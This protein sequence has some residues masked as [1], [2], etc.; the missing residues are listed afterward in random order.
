MIIEHILDPYPRRMW[1]A[2][3]E[4]F[5]KIK[6]EFKFLCQ[7]DCEM[8]NDEIINLYDAF[9]FD[10][11]KDN[12]LGYLIFIITTNSNK[13]LVHESLHVSLSIYI[14]CNMEISPKMDQEPLCY[15]TEYIYSLLESDISNKN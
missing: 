2:I 8:S 9:V 10:V 4:D 13:I 6:S 15:L 14:D 12:Y 5:D 7:K 1:V 3:D 11:S